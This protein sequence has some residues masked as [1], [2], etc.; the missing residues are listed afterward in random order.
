MFFPDHLDIF[1]RQII[2]ACEIWNMDDVKDLLTDTDVITK[3]V[4]S[5]VAFVETADSYDSWNRGAL[6]CMKG[7]AWAQREVY[8][9]VNGSKG[10]VQDQVCALLLNSLHFD[11]M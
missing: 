7:P 5:M 1:D 10:P 11:L 6:A 2:K 9:A 4:E 3:D 8:Q